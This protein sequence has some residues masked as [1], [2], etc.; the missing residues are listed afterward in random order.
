MRQMSPFNGT[1][2][3]GGLNGRDGMG[4][5]AN[6]QPLALLGVGQP[7]GLANPPGAPPGAGMS[8]VGVVSLFVKRPDVASQLAADR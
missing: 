1:I 6:R 4:R 8:Q 2:S 5:A 3:A 7:S